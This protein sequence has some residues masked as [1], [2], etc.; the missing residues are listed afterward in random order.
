MR[1]GEDLHTQLDDQMDSQ[2]E[3]LKPGE[4]FDISNNSFSMPHRVN[5]LT[6]LGG[7]IAPADSGVCHHAQ[8][9]T[10]EQMR[11]RENS[12]LRRCYLLPR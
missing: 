8:K 12:I 9:S 10:S 3:I 1:V 4:Y 5:S 6:M 11:A 7:K 2:R